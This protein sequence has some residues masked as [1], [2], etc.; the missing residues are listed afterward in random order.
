MSDEYKAFFT[1]ATD[2][3]APYNYQERLA[4]EPCI[5]RLISV[6]T[7]LGKTAAVTLAWLYNRQQPNPTWPRRLVYCLPM[8]TLVEQTR[9]E[10]KKW[11][12]NL[13]KEGLI[14]GKA[15]CVI[16]LMGGEDLEGEDK[17]WD[18]YPEGDAIL[19]GTQDML[20]SRALNRGYGM[21][22]YRWP[23][24]FGLLNHDCL[25]VLDE[26]QLMG[27][28]L[29]TAG[30]LDWMRQHR[31]GVLKPCFTWWMRATPSPVFNNS[32]ESFGRCG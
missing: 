17:D 4:N 11:I 31:F 5:S 28:G 18:L 32:A 2:K 7:G 21:S 3:A 19:I 16:L 14:T 29:W 23:M 24:P 15:P 27:P 12:E 20:L 6:P 30:Q 10:A 25:W 22:R 8:R 26:T 9:D 1:A 13:S